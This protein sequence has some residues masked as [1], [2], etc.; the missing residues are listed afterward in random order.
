M[1]RPGGKARVLRHV[2]GAGALAHG[3]FARVRLN[4]PGQNRQQRG[5]ARAVGADQADPVAVLDGERNVLKQRLGAELLGHGL[6]V[7]NRRHLF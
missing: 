2:S 7:E 3:Q 6:R 4:L 5:F 1:V